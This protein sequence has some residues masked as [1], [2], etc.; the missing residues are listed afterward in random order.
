M[1]DRNPEIL[2]TRRVREHLGI[3]RTT[4][5]KLRQRPD[6]PRPTVLNGRLYWKATQLLAWAKGLPAATAEDE[7]A[8]RQRLPGYRQEAVS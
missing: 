2:S 6:F 7:K 8:L 4:L 5:W 3:S 1:L